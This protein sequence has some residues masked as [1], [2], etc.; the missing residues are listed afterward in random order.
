MSV[1]HCEGCQVR[2]DS[3]FIELVDVGGISYCADSAP[4]VP[5]LVARVEQLE[6]E[7][8]TLRADL[9]WYKRASEKWRTWYDDLKAGGNHDVRDDRIT[10]G[11]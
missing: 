6:A 9:E 1:F 3:D 4:D 11:T 5:A 10:L 7:T 2:H 8:R